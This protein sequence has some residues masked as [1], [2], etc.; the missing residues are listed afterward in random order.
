M[1]GGFPKKAFA[2]ELAMRGPTLII[3]EFCT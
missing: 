1:F 2:R 3:R